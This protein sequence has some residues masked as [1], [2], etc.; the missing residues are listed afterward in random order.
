MKYVVLGARLLI[1]A[2]FVYASIYKVFDPA[3]FAGSVRNY[4]I[5][6]SAWSNL[7]ALT[8]PWVELAAGIFLILGIETRP[9][10]LLTTG[11]LGMFLGAIVY[12]YS[13]GLDIDCGC[14]GS[15]AGS[16]GRIGLLTIARDSSLFLASAFVLLM[17]RGDFSIS[18]I[19]GS[20]FRLLNA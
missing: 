20:R 3:S 4:L 2:L 5:V 13:I 12:A 8:L 17:D 18:A 11:M 16:S 19:L 9:S 15:A 7:I 1:G 14:F 6:P 10:A